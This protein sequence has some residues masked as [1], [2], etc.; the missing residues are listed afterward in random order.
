MEKWTI[1]LLDL[2]NSKHNSNID[3]GVIGFKEEQV[4]DLI[5]GIIQKGRK[6]KNGC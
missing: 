6:K 4:R 1:K 3:L 5:S 2:N